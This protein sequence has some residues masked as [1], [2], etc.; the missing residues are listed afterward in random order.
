MRSTASFGAILCSAAYAVAQYS[1]NTL[2]TS[3]PAVAG[4][5]TAPFPN[6][7]YPDGVSPNPMAEEGAQ[8]NQTSPPI[9]PSPWGTGAGD[10]SAAYEKAI[11]MVQQMTLEEKVNI[12]TG[13]T[14]SLRVH[15]KIESDI[16]QVLVGLS[17]PVSATLAL[18]LDLAS[19]PS[20]FRIHQPLCD[21][22][23]ELH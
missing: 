20:A 13:K 1:N 18:F 5:D 14:S 21:L 9:Y 19:G 3:A 11:A 8:Y 23:S 4:N 7:T 12:T 17:V 15:E 6:V 10:W 2:P 16:E 22:A